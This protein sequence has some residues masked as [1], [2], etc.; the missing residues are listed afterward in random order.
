MPTDGAPTTVGGVYTTRRLNIDTKRGSSQLISLKYEIKVCSLIGAWFLFP[1]YY[2]CFRSL[3][4]LVDLAVLGA[5]I[6]KILEE[7][8]SENR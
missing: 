8:E 6:C 2:R 5:E 4:L 1:L 7:T 3:S